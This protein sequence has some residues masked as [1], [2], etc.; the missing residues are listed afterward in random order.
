MDTEEWIKRFSD[1][2]CAKHGEVARAKAEREAREYINGAST[3]DDPESTAEMVIVFWD[4]RGGWGGNATESVIYDVVKVFPEKVLLA[5]PGV[6][7]TAED[8]DL[9]QVENPP[10]D[11]VVGDQMVVRGGR[12]TWSR[13]VRIPA[14]SSSARTKE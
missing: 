7:W 13:F 8:A 10:P 4:K 14:S 3:E 5:L 11:I 6:D 9:K 2:I 1:R 12:A